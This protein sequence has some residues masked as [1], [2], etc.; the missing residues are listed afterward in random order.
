MASPVLIF[1]TSHVGKS[2]LA[3]RLGERLGWPVH[4]T[5]KMGRHPG[6]PWPEVREPVAEYYTRLS[7]ET[8]YWFLLVHQNNIWPHISQQIIKAAA[9]QTGSVF[10]G[11][12]LRPEFFASLEQVETTPIGLYADEAFLRDRMLAESGYEQRQAPQRL[13]IDKFITRSLRQNADFFET[14]TRLGLPMINVADSEALAS[15][16]EQ[17]V[18]TLN[19]P[20]NA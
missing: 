6:R 4:S 10:E 19:G 14:A 7:D 11:S 2:T 18:A 3:S 12:A 9:G 15:A 16:T 8:I 1:G 13:L 17:L 5:D 20:G